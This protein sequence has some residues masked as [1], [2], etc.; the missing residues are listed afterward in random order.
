[1]NIFSNIG[2]TELIVIL[3]LALLVVGPER[4]PELGQK[5]GKALRDVRAMYENLTKDLGPE[6]ASFQETTRE[7]RESVESVRSI[8][9]DM[10]KTVTQAADLDDTIGELR[11]VAEEVGQVSSAI[12]TA[13]SIVQSP[14]KAAVSAAQDTL[15]PPSDQEHDSVLT[16]VETSVKSSAGTGEPVSEQQDAERSDEGPKGEG[17]TPP[18]SGELAEDTSDE[19]GPGNGSAELEAEP[20]EEQATTAPERDGD[21]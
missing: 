11:Q 15:R 16:E 18:E 3:L 10:V 4:L 21:E 9:Q 19:V 5:L 8:P 2:I 14:I 12:S 7:L 20:P 6:L 17:A 13:G 1:M